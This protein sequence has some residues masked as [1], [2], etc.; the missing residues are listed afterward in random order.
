MYTN[1]ICFG[2]QL[3]LPYSNISIKKTFTIDHVL[4]E[5]Q[6][7]KLLIEIPYTLLEKVYG[8]HPY[9]G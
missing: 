7:N 4:S 6:S 1:D 8:A 9:K 2:L 3:N 5:R